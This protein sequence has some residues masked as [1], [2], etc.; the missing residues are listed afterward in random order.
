MHPLPILVK[1]KE[2]RHL[3]AFIAECDVYIGNDTGPM[4]IAAAV[5]TPVVALF[6]STNHHRSGPYGEKHT[7]VQRWAAVRMQSVSSGAEIRGDVV[8]VAAP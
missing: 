3:A 7:V 6:G 2:L 5:D 4:H 8:P 1:T